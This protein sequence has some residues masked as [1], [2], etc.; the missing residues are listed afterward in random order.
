MCRTVVD[1]WTEVKVCKVAGVKRKLNDTAEP[2]DPCYRWSIAY[3]AGMKVMADGRVL[4]KVVWKSDEYRAG[5]PE[6]EWMTEVQMDGGDN[7]E[8][9]HSRYNIPRPSVVGFPKVFEW[10]FDLPIS[11]KSRDG[12][13]T[14]RC[15]HCPYSEGKRSN[16]DVHIVCKHQQCPALECVCGNQAGTKSNFF[17]HVKKCRRF[18]ELVSPAEVV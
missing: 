12:K 1:G 8:E 6:F 13:V 4:Y 2:D 9:F 14:Y 18:H 11:T 10:E 15:P 3:I 17:R 5:A 7:V 16:V